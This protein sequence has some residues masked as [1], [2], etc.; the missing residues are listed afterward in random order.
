MSFF[1]CNRIWALRLVWIGTQ[2]PFTSSSLLGTL[3]K[4]YVD[5]KTWQC[6]P[7]G[8]KETWQIHHGGNVMEKEEI[9]AKARQEGTLG[10]DDGSKHMRARGRVI[11]WLLSSVVF[12]V[13][14]VLS[15]MTGHPIDAGVRAMFLAYLTGETYMEWNMKKSKLALF[16]SIALGFN[17]GLALIDVAC[18]ML[19][20]IL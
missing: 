19:G 18:K 2:G 11:G 4:T 9:L 13:I 15:L 10:V 12:L 17:A 6:Y 5:Q 1:L 7:D 8:A 16:L 3:Y 20:V 14:A